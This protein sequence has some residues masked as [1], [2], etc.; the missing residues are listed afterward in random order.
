MDDKEIQKRIG[1]GSILAQVAFEVLGSPKEHV[2]KTIHDFVDN[3]RKDSFITI[4]SEDYGET[5]ETPEGGL[6]STYVETEMLFPDLEKFVWLCINFMPASIEIIAPA[7]LKFRDKD[8]TL[9][10]NDLL[11]KLHEISATVR[12]ATAKEDLFVK[13]MNAM[14]Q[15][16][17][18]LAAEHHHSPEQISEKTGIPV[19]QLHPFFEALV[20]A[21]KLEK[22]GDEYYRNF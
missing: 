21:Q 6:W 13:N 14:I 2:D 9:W 15:N 20:K 3:I 18:L 1:K 12:Q 19:E 11:A 7:E 16:T 8:L 10:L 4:L 17:M 5:E 22:K